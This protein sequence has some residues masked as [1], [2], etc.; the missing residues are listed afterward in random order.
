MAVQIAGDSS[1]EEADVK[2]A[3]E[4][5][6]ESDEAWEPLVVSFTY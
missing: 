6:V 2:K 5:Y 3:W 4:A 1:E